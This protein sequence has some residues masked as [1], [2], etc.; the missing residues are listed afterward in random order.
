MSTSK[1]G[2]HYFGVG[3]LIVAVLAIIA[4]T[5]LG[6]AAYRWGKGVEKE[7]KN[8]DTRRARVLEILAADE[9]PE[10][11]NAML[12]VRVP[13]MMQTAILTD[14]EAEPGED[15][16]ELGERGFLYF[17]LRNFG[18]DREDLN[19]FFEGRTDNPDVLDRHHINVDLGERVANGRI[20]RPTGAILWVSHR[21]EMASGQ[22]RGRHEGLITLLQIHC[23]DNG[24]NRLGMWFGPD[25]AEQ[26]DP[27]AVESVA[28]PAAVEAFAGYFRFCPE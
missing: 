16:P 22:T 11:Y 12:G 9:L 5:G 17:A 3:C 14:L 25:P 28:D 4:A 6:F 10:G 8:P 24:Y 19:D 20:D 2:F 7:L 23:P 26:E 15:L 27:D 18:R 1:S 13:M 21:G